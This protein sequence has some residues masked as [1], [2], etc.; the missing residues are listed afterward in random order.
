MKKIL[1]TIGATIV[2]LCILIIVVACVQVSNEDN[3]VVVTPPQFT[4]EQGTSAMVDEIA[5]AARETAPDMSSSQ[6]D[7][8]ITIIES[9]NHDYYSDYENMEKFMWYGCLLQYKYENDEEGQLGTDL[10]QAIKYVYR[11]VETVDDNATVE[12][13]RQIDEHLSNL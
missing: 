5:R 8:L 12:N 11:G 1:I 6:A 4:S 2:G 3:T 13:L 10:Y 9:A 7:E